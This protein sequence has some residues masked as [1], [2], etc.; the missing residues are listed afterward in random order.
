MKMLAFQDMPYARPDM[1]AMKQALT[2]ATEALHSAPGYE[3]ARSAFFAL[4]EQEKQNMTMMSLASVCNTID[5]TDEYYDGEMKWIREQSA[6]LIPLRKKY[7]E[8]L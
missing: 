7:Q 3:E 8:A 1:D 6:G 5:T 4:Q 2:T